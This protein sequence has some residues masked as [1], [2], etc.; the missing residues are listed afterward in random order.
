MKRE[1]WWTARKSTTLSIVVTWV[2]LVAAVACLPLLASIVWRVEI[3][4]LFVGAA[5]GDEPSSNKLWLLVVA[6]YVCLA[7]G[8]VA[9]ILLLRLLIDIRG[10]KVF[11][12]RNVS[13]L[14]SISYCGFVIAVVSVVIVAIQPYKLVFGLM[15][16][17]AAFL[18]LLMRVI[19]NVIDT[20]RELKEESDYTI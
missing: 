14:K 18:G 10:E 15:A 16:A 3:F 7:A 19:K 8:I 1:I 6:L 12:S 11:T 13:R 4:S 5:L 2:A 20:A 17:A 9:L